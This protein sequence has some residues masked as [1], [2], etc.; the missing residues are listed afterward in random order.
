MADILDELL[1][2]VNVSPNSNSYKLLSTQ[3]SQ[4]I[5]N[6]VSIENI[7][8]ELKLS[9]YRSDEIVN[10]VHKL[11]LRNKKEA[12]E[13]LSGLT[14]SNVLYLK[15]LLEDAIRNDNTK[16]ALEIIK[17]L[18]KMVPKKIEKNADAEQIVIQFS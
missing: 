9:G 13:L 2:A 16:N 1:D 3:I 6:G 11:Y 17:E 10:T 5:R 15:A 14:K 12:N 18:N 7:L 8:E 4:K